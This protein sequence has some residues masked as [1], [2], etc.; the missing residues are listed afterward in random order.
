MRRNFSG[1]YKIYIIYKLKLKD[2]IRALKV[3]FVCSF[4]Y[5]LRSL[6]FYFLFEK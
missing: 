6:I 4:V 3:V 1:D 5:F 2:V